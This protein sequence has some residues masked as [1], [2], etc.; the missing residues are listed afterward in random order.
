MRRVITRAK[1]RADPPR[2]R[3]P[4]GGGVN[5]GTMLGDEDVDDDVNEKRVKGWRHGK[6]RRKG[7]RGECIVGRG[8]LWVVWVWRAGLLVYT[9]GAEE[10]YTLEIPGPRYIRSERE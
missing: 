10:V 2:G 5:S 4:G 7:R 6:D 8:R 1:G 9:F 3:R